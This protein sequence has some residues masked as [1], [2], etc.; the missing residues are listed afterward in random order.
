MGIVALQNAIA[1]WSVAAAAME[2]L[3]F[4]IWVFVNPSGALER[5]MSHES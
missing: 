2:V 3:H 4:S 1:I 5:P